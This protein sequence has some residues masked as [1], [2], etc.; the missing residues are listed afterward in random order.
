MKILFITDESYLF[1]ATMSA[2]DHNDRDGIFTSVGGNL[3]PVFLDFK[4]M[5]IELTEGAVA[6]KRKFTPHC[7]V[8]SPHPPLQPD[9]YH[10]ITQ[11]LQIP[12]PSIKHS[13]KSSSPPASDTL[14]TLIQINR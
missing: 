6:E 11:N 4:N 9:K 8:E 7:G 3:N 5:D 2:K 12:E 14:F 10:R 1:L 13:F